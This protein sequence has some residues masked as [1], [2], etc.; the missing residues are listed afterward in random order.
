MSH[1][2][3]RCL[4][5]AT[6]TASLENGGTTVSGSTMLTRR[7][8]RGGGGRMTG[9]RVSYYYIPVVPQQARIGTTNRATQRTLHLGQRGVA[10]RS[11]TADMNKTKP[12]KMSF[13]DALTRR[14]VLFPP[15]RPVPISQINVLVKL[16][17]TGL[18][19]R[20]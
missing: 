12:T 1:V 15:L 2:V 14:P 10:E 18:A 19:Y 11:Q 16:Q 7:E 13:K 3:R 9:K 17:Y 4:R 20:S 5:S 6:L 8:R